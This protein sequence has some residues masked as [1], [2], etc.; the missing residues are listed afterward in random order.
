[1]VR[2]SSGT[3]TR[4]SPADP[5]PAAG[6]LH[7]F[8]YTSHECDFAPGDVFLGFTDG[9][10]EAQ[11]SSGQ[12]FGQQRVE[13]FLANTKVGA[14]SDLCAQLL[15]EVEDYSHRKLFEDDVCIVAVEAAK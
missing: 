2:N 1:L 14:T 3:L 13:N 6:L 5:E 10:V 9:V 11:D 4:L 15:A 12:M 7:E 8:P